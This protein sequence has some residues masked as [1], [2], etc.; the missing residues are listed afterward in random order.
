MI[1]Q[2]RQRD[3]TSF[4]KRL[5]WEKRM[6]VFFSRTLR[7]HFRDKTLY[8]PNMVWNEFESD[9]V[10]IMLEYVNKYKLIYLLS[11]NYMLYI[12]DF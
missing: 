11:R 10:E 7:N 5:Q 4:Q 6:R 1:C 8:D 3:T 12:Y 2:M 9:I